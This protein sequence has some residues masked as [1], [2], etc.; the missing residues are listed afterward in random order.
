MKN[1]IFQTCILCVTAMVG[2]G[3]ASTKHLDDAEGHF[4]SGR[5]A[6]AAISA[7]SRFPE[8]SESAAERGTSKYILDNLYS[9]SA[10]LMA[11]NAAAASDSFG[12]AADGIAEQD[13][14][15]FGSGY[16]TRTYDV[17]MAAGYK[18]LARWMEGDID[19]TRIAFRLTADAQD[20]ADERNAKAIRK[21]EDEAE[22][23][24]A[25][26]TSKAESDA[27]AKGG[28][29]EGMLDSFLG[30]VSSGD[31]KQQLDEFQSQYN[32]WSVYENFQI[33]STW[34]L[35]ALFSLANAED[36][37]DLEHASFC[38]RK[39]LGMVPEPSSPPIKS[40]YD[41]AEARA[42]GKLSAAKLNQ[43]FAVVF[44]NGLGPNIEEQRFDIPIPYRGDIYL[45]S[46]ALPKLVTRSEAYSSVIVRDGAVPLGETIPI[47]ELD[48]VAVRE[49]RSRLPGIVASQ[50]FE[51][52]V[53]LVVQVAIVEAVK[54]KNGEQAGFLASLATSAI[55]AAITGT[56][57]RHWNLLPKN[58]Q[59][60]I[61]KKP[62]SEDRMV[63]L[64]IPG[65][66]EPLAKVALPE[67]GLSVVYVKV[68]APG[69][70]PLVRLLG[71]DN[72]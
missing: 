40:V 4:L 72:P 56:D 71:Q 19:G 29:T 60:C 20:R 26:E 14:S 35:D 37:N 68:P 13:D 11:G 8:D 48:K 52:T 38:A 66:V 23:R 64:W 44:E 39:A 24:K 27:A 45:L 57:T 34:F 69:L 67:K 5:Y 54:K 30:I 9:G 25:E 33:P 28:S 59:A 61:L 63:E 53:K 46:F 1:E 31:A 70:P 21:A 12:Y 15:T 43:V 36:A 6:D 22:K 65:A 42:D 7:A 10:E 47:A 50:I 58:I 2:A 41:F 18:A 3:C 62:S 16:P 49:F 55:S 17:S 51:A 32:E